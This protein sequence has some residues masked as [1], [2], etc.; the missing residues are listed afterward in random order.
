MR[1]NNKVTKIIIMKLTNNTTLSLIATLTAS[2]AL[3]GAAHSAIIYQDDFNTDGALNGS[4]SS[5]GE[6]WVNTSSDDLYKLV[7]LLIVDGD[8]KT[9]SITG[10]TLSVNT[11]YSLSMDVNVT[12]GGS[13]WFGMGFRTNSFVHIISGTAASMLHRNSPAVQMFTENGGYGQGAVAGTGLQNIE[14]ILT[15]GSSLANSTVSYAVDGVAVGSTQNINAN[16]VDGVFLATRDTARGYIDNFELRADAVPEPSSTALLG[17]G[18]LAL[19]LR[20]RKA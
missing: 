16:G 10:L 1:L 3:L 4:I 18:G 8:D 17:L 12:A 9:A 7:G 6:N 5:H 19:I 15:T 2:A 20:R 11:T 14:I 13:D